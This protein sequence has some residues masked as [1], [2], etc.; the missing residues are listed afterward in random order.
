MLFYG[1]I[2]GNIVLSMSPLPSLF[3]LCP[4][5]SCK[6]LVIFHSASYEFDLLAKLDFSQPLYVDFL[7]PK[8]FRLNFFVGIG[9]RVYLLCLVGYPFLRYLLVQ[10]RWQQEIRI[11]LP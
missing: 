1:H 6:F 2:F 5:F 10:L 8:L 11:L 7:K 9:L 3:L 4:R